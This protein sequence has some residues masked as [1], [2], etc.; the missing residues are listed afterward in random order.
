MFHFPVGGGM[1]MTSTLRSHSRPPT[2]IAQSI[3]IAVLGPEMPHS[4]LRHIAT[5]TVWAPSS[6]PAL[7]HH[8]T[9]FD[10]TRA[11]ARDRRS[12]PPQSLHAINTT[13]SQSTED[14]VGYED[15]LDQ[16][17]SGD[18]GGPLV[19]ISKV[20]L[21]AAFMY[22]PHCPNTPIPLYRVGSSSRFKILR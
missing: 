15:P 4:I 2:A 8:C 20:N 21:S 12:S 6:K 11:S 14:G 22:W 19:L 16:F 1:N 13:S 3:T 5:S 7:S 9:P 18:A 10:T 17:L